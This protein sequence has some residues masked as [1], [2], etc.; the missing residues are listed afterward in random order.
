MIEVVDNLLPKYYLK[1]LQEYFISSNSEWY[2]NDNISGSEFNSDLESSGFSM[3]LFSMETGPINNFAGLVS[4]ALPFTL[5]EKVEDIMGQPYSLVR[6]RAVMTLYS[7]QS[8]QHEIHTDM[9]VDNITCIFYMNTSD[10][11]TLI[12]D[13]DGK[14]LLKE[15][16]PVE[17]RVVIFDGKYPHAGHSPS[18][19]K[20]RVLI[21]M[22]FVPSKDL[23]TWQ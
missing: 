9:E 5:Q 16:E 18:K 15:I 2:Y 11:N 12:Y 6:T 21:N 7:F 8:Y 14:T 4:R 3:R 19:N 20:N 23:R 17:N 1:H 10:G 13:K 22:N